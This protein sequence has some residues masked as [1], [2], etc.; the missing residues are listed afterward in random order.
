MRFVA[1]CISGVEACVRTELRN[2]KIWTEETEDRLVAFSGDFSTLALA[3]AT[4]RTANRVYVELAHT[5]ATSF[6][7]LFEIIRTIPWKDWLS[8]LAPVRIR[9][10]FTT[11]NPA[12]ASE[13]AVQRITKKALA[14]SITGKG[15]ILAESEQELPCD[16]L[17]L[18][19]NDQVRVLLNTSGEALHK[20]TARVSTV[21]APLKESLAAALLMLSGWQPGKTL[22][23]PCAGG[24][25]I[26]LEAISMAMNLA[27]GLLR[28]A[29]Y[30]FLRFPIFPQEAWAQTMAL[31]KSQVVSRSSLDR[32]Q[33]FVSDIDPRALRSIT[34]NAQELDVLEYISI[35]EADARTIIP[36]KITTDFLISN[37]PYGLRL[38]TQ[39]VTGVHNALRACFE[40]NPSLLGGVITS[41]EDFMARMNDETR[42][43]FRHRKLMNGGETV[44]FYSRKL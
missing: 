5:Q 34:S 19:S 7:S 35:T 33:F 31:L 14:E 16:I 15:G 17:L 10:V 32:D 6:D 9:A 36:N 13:V 11:K 42:S 3:N 41:E 44:G 39:D 24:G 37:P 27:P 30:D 40:Q 25:T 20:R 43:T 22:M 38:A 29:R 26:V 1:T 28:G 2:Q 12:L 8:P 4:L 21:D 18:L 23:D